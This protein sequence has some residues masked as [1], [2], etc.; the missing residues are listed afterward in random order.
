MDYSTVT[1]GRLKNGMRWVSTS[2]PTAKS[3]TFQMLTLAGSRSEPEGKR[4]MAHLI[5]H[6]F[7]TGTTKHSSSE[8]V[9]Q[10]HDYGGE[11]NADTG[12]DSC[13]YY[14]KIRSPHL[15]RVLSFFSEVLYQ[16]TFTPEVIENEKE[17]VLN[18]IALRTGSPVAMLSSV[19]L[20]QRAWVGTPACHPV[21]GNET[22]IRSI[23]RDDVLAFI[24]QMYQPQS[25]VLSIAGNLPPNLEALLEKYFSYHVKSRGECLVPLATGVLQTELQTYGVSNG[26]DDA[27]IAIAFPYS[28]VELEKYIR[29][30]NYVLVDTMSSRLFKKLRSELGLIY[31]VVPISNELRDVG[32]FGFSVTTKNSDKNVKSCVDESLKILKEVALNGITEIELNQAKAYLVESKLLALEDSSTLANY[33]GEQLLMRKEFMPYNEGIEEL[34]RLRLEEL[35]W[36]CKRLFVDER[37]NL[38]IIN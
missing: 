6:L 16:S 22:D 13:N 7:F 19:L 37:M 12:V 27:V 28:T 17:V 11:L 18:E 33:Y 23:T 4:G 2:D 5:E 35:R 32:M 26:T 31:A 14:C 10:I 38:A 34:K 1:T 36:A 25:I 9:Q 3:V 30:L 29:V 21:G 20:P 15:E 8:L 24:D